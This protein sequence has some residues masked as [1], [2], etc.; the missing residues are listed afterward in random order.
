MLYSRKQLPKYCRHKSS[1]RAFVR[2][3]GKMYYTLSALD[4]LFFFALWILLFF[5]FPFCFRK[6][7]CTGFPFLPPT[8]NRFATRQALFA[9]PRVSK[10][11]NG[12]LLVAQNVERTIICKHLGI[13]RNTLLSYVKLFLAEGLEGLKRNNYVPPTSALEPHAATLEEYFD[14]HPP[15]SVANAIDVIKRLTGL[16]YKKSFVHKWLISKGYRFRKT[17][18]IPAKANV[19]L[20]E[21]FKKNA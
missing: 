6:H 3:G 19:A 9:D 1:G 12:I 4:L 15:H 7:S 5:L 13:T 14:K 11:L 8:L 18:G 17:G 20:Q 21:E 2:I 16:D 10:K